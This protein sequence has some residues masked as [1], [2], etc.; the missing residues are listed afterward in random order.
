MSTSIPR[1]VT[2][3]KSIVDTAVRRFS[4]WPTTAADSIVRG[5]LGLVPRS[6]VD[7]L[8]T[9]TPYTST[10]QRPHSAGAAPQPSRFVDEEEI[11]WLESG[12]HELPY[13]RDTLWAVPQMWWEMSFGQIGAG[14]YLAGAAVHNPVAM[15]VGWGISSAFKG[16]LLLADLGR[17]ERLTH[18]FRKPNTS[19]IARGAWAFAGLAVAG[20]VSLLPVPPVVRTGSTAVAA[21]CA[22]VVGSYDGLFLHESK[23][24]GAWTEPVLPVLFAVNGMSGGL[25]VSNALS[26]H[27]W[28]RGASVVGSVAGAGLAGWYGYELSQ[29]TTAQRLSARDLLEGKQR[30]RFVVL[31]IGAGG[32]GAAVLSAATS[33]ALRA[34]GGALAMT[35]VVSMRRAVLEAGIHAPVIDPPRGTSNPMDHVAVSKGVSHD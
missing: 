21:A 27:P 23:A 30:D 15:G 26:T 34:L 25:L 18:V 13:R 6:E 20:G 22:A 2:W 24:V 29:G 31:G 3:G 19:W 32:L 10:G 5:A 28:L 33:P 9:T 14:A 12:R 8:R 16:V 17:P 4:E 7:S 1:I 11:S 35:G